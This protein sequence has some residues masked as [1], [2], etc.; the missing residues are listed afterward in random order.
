M[1]VRAS[2]SAPMILALCLVGAASLSFAQSCHPWDG[3][4]RLCNQ[5]FERGQPIYVRED[6]DWDT[7]LEETSS[8]INSIVTSFSSTETGGCSSDFVEIACG[9][10]LRPCLIRDG[11]A[12]PYPQQTCR[13]NCEEFVQT[14]QFSYNEINLPIGHGL[15]L[16][17]NVTSDLTCDELDFRVEGNPA[18][19]PSGNYTV[20][21][22]SAECKYYE[23]LRYTCVEPLELNEELQACSYT[24]PLPSLSPSQ[25]EAVKVMQLVL[26]WIS[27]ICSFTVVLSYIVHPKLR[28]YP[29]NL[30]MMTCISANIAAFAF[31][32]PTFSGHDLIWCGGEDEFYDITTGYTQVFL[33]LQP[34]DLRKSGGW[35][36][37]QGFVLQFGFQSGTFWWVFIALNMVMQLFW[38]KKLKGRA[39][40]GLQIAFHVCAWGIP[41]F[42]SLVP[43]VAG[44]NSFESASTFCFISAENEQAWQITFWFV[45]VGLLLSIGLFFF[46]C[47]VYFVVKLTFSPGGTQTKKRVGAAKFLALYSRLIAFM[48]LFLVLYLIIFSYTIA[49]T[50]NESTITKGYADYYRCLLNELEDCSLSNSVTNYPL[51]V[52]RAFAYSSLGFWLAV[53]FLNREIFAFWNSKLGNV[54]PG[55]RS[56]GLSTS[57]P[58]STQTTKHM[59]S[60]TFVDMSVVDE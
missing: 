31:V 55:L 46:C 27:W 3:V 20:A 15:L 6:Y 1:G 25:Y 5:Y 19:F 50:A 59:Q 45:P 37:L 11:V 14:C 8:L 35:C 39:R 7:L 56:A 52:L 21:N 54:I 43:A 44:K 42:L 30:V 38:G 24:C 9:T 58:S 47:A 4:P 34:Q 12:L 48:F 36:A 17:F 26:G 57:D 60:D 18:L 28:K 10:S 13:P 22:I 51:V 40:L 53:L 41:F 49:V 32:M 16:P 33:D 23:A 2:L 29:S